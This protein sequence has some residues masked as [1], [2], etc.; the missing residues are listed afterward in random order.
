[1]AALSGSTFTGLKTRSGRQWRFR[2]EKQGADSLESG[3]LT[4][5]CLGR[6]GESRETGEWQAV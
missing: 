6:R 4:G 3:E 5:G 1:M 2:T